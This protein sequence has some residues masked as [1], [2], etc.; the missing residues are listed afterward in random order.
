M[1]A[2]FRNSAAPS[3]ELTGGLLFTGSQPAAPSTPQTPQTT[4]PT[5]PPFWALVALGSS[6]EKV[7][8]VHTAWSQFVSTWAVPRHMALDGG[9]ELARGPAT[10]SLRHTSHA[11]SDLPPH[12]APCDRK[13][14]LP[15]NASLGGANALPP[16]E[17]G[18]DAGLQ[19]VGRDA[20][21]VRG[22]RCPN[23]SG[24]IM[25]RRRLP[26]WTWLM[27]V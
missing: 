11:S 2:P 8:N 6:L 16:E 18:L 12:T 19:A 17:L 15:V 23:S 10:G 26:V 24:F 21:T 3:T 13:A 20:S 1:H 7:L 22:F 9:R 25:R 5:F 4:K 14:G 27:F